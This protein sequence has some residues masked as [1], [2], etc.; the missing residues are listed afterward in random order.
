MGIEEV[1]QEVLELRKAK[2]EEIGVTVVRLPSSAGAPVPAHCSRL[3]QAIGQVI[4]G[5]LRS[6]ASQPERCLA[7]GYR[8]VHRGV[9]I[10]IDCSTGGTRAVGPAMHTGRQWLEEGV[11]ELA[12]CRQMLDEC[13]ARAFV[14]APAQGWAR[15][16]IELSTEPQR[17][18]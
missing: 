14:S 8:S 3:G 10:E 13:G 9:V 16:V 4:D 17:T 2:F 12:Q 15:F 5:A 7:V 11:A 6:L 18:E 1:L